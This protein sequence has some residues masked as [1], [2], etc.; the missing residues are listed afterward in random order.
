MVGVLL[1]HR[2]R[3]NENRRMLLNKS[4]RPIDNS[5]YLLNDRNRSPRSPVGR[6]SP[7]QIPDKARCAALDDQQSTGAVQLSHPSSLMAFYFALLNVSNVNLEEVNRR[8]RHRRHDHSGSPQ[9]H[10]HSRSKSAERLAA[11]RLESIDAASVNS[12]DATLPLSDY[13]LL[14]RPKVVATASAA[15]ND[16]HALCHRVPRPPTPPHVRKESAPLVVAIEHKSSLSSVGSLPTTYTDVKLSPPER[17]I[18]LGTPLSAPEEVVSAATSPSLANGGP[19]PMRRA[20]VLRRRG[21]ALSGTKKVTFMADRRSESQELL[22][23]RD[24]SNETRTALELQH[25]DQSSFLGLRRPHAPRANC[26][27]WDRD[28]GWATPPPPMGTASRMQRV[29]EKLIVENG[30][31]VPALLRRA[32][33]Q[34]PRLFRPSLSVRA[35]IRVDTASPPTPRLVRRSL[36]PSIVPDLCRLD[37]RRFA[38][39]SIAS[40]SRRRGPSNGADRVCVPAPPPLPPPSPVSRRQ[41]LEAA[42]LAPA[43]SSS[44]SSRSRGPLNGRTPNGESS[45]NSSNRQQAVDRAKAAG[46]VGKDELTTSLQNVQNERLEDKLRFAQSGARP[47]TSHVRDSLPPLT[48]SRYW[49]GLPVLRRRSTSDRNREER[50]EMDDAQ[51]ARDCRRSR[52]Y[53]HYQSS[54][55]NPGF[56]MANEE[57]SFS[58]PSSPRQ[59]DCGVV[60][61][62]PS[63]RRPPCRVRP[64]SCY[65]GIFK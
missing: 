30:R 39:F 28:A 52:K 56:T 23:E 10:R 1:Y 65:D 63:T 37:G 53:K 45:S 15:S 38:D 41:S 57:P 2:A 18:S 46:G 43:N 20:S 21:S 32:A 36:P 49:E 54:Y 17:K 34:S 42:A 62:E 60:G 29:I 14:P 59:S 58:A 47:R 12:L 11:R 6:R 5:W 26:R 64:N 3:D 55:M 50:V 31:K 35:D 16:K 8:R 44:S 61:C 48:R 25:G 51:C 33:S 27:Q 9:P 4:E 40:A 19:V 24:V 22:L 7:V 13:R